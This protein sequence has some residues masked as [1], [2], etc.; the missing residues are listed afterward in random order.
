[1]FTALLR[2]FVYQD[3]VQS[4]ET[5][6]YVTISRANEFSIQTQ[7]EAQQHLEESIAELTCE[8]RG[9]YFTTEL[10]TVSQHN[11]RKFAIYLVTTALR[12]PRFTKGPT[13]KRE[14]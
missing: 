1:M 7:S 3:V 10:D 4:S 5:H 8:I 14:T 11:L 2:V 9:Y 13:T 6:F 12:G